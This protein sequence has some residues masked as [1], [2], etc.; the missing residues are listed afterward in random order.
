[1]RGQTKDLNL[2]YIRVKGEDKQEISMIKETIRIGTGQIA[3]IEDYNLVVEFNTDRIIEVDQGMT[4][5]IGMTIG[6]EILKG[7]W[8]CI[9]IRTLGDK[10]IEVDIEETIEMTMKEVGVGLEKSHTQVILEGMTEV[11]VTV[12]QGQDQE[13]VLIDR[14]RCY[15]CREWDHFTK[16][17]PTAKEERETDQIQQMFY[18]DEDHTSL[19][20][21]ATDTY[22]NLNCVSSVEEV[23]SEHLNL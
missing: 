9:K 14:I 12:G 3:E 10:I 20:T 6:G 16:D 23:R 11:T 15:M 8:E 18:L 5:I 13:Q 2:W 7:M 1:M 21:L 17:C 19:K 4:R 22:D